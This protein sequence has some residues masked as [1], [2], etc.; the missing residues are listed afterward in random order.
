MSVLCVVGLVWGVTQLHDVVFVVCRWSSTILRFNATTHQQLTGIV[1]K[2]LEFPLDIAACE[3][4]SHVYVAEYECI[5]R[6]SADGADI[7]HWLPKSPDD[8]FKP[9]ALS[10]TST[11]LLVTPYDTKLMQFDADGNE[12]RRVHLP[13]YMEPLHAVESPTGTFIVSH[14]TQLKQWQVSEVNTGGEVLR[15]FTGSRLS[16]LGRPIHVAVDSHGNIFVADCN[17]RRIS[18]LD[19][20][21][22]LRRVIIDEHQLN[23]KSPGCLCYREQ[24]GQLVVGLLWGVSVFDV[25]HFPP[26][27]LQKKRFPPYF[28]H[29]AFAPSFILSRRPWLRLRLRLRK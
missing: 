2:D 20:Q 9:W 5:L 13:D 11:R 16:P 22:T 19:A 15:Q 24:S 14:Y 6:V 27:F 23:Y 28:F 10:V 26:K 3:L 1:V 7:K 17:N 12:L 8:T 29:G 25:V 21:L 18:L 4:T